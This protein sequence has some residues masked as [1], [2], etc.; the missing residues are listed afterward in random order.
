MKKNKLL[1]KGTVALIA[2]AMLVLTLSGCGSSSDY[3]NGSSAKYA[4]AAMAESA[5]YVGDYGYDYD[6]YESDAY[7]ES[8]ASGSSEPVE[9]QDSSRKLITTYNLSV[10]TEEFDGFTSFLDAK[11][12]ELGGYI[13]DLSEYKGSIRNSYDARYS[14]MTVR[15]PS[16]RAKEFLNLVGENANITNQDMNVEDVTLRY[17]DTKSEKEAYVVEQQRLMELLEQAETMEDILTIESRLSEVRYKIDSTESQLRTY[18]NLVD[19]TTFYINI[20]EVETYTEPEPESYGARLWNSLT[21]GLSDTAENLGDFFV[22]FL[23]ALPG[24]LVFAVI[25]GGIFFIVF[26]IVRSAKKRNAK[27]REAQ[28]KKMQEQQM[29][30]QMQMMAQSQVMTQSNMA[31]AQ[32]EDQVRK[33]QMAQAQANAQAQQGRAGTQAAAQAQQ[34]Q[35]QAAQPQAPEQP[36]QTDENK[37]E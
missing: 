31:R 28:A 6:L 11:V 5:S 19:Y 13:Q 34:A 15:I 21:E 1:R 30:M 25:S 27:K 16:N 2:S 33:A 4:D 9:V 29:Q 24:L 32:A 23:W 12:T 3:S 18:D 22:G 35:A 17:V 36:Q 20:S 37:P 14:N 26:A 10:E 8:S 7:E